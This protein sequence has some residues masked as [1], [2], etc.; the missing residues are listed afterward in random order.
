L[1]LLQDWLTPVEIPV[2]GQTVSHYKIVEHLG[3]GGPARRRP[4]SHLRSFP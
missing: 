3:T 1:F 4:T 2:I